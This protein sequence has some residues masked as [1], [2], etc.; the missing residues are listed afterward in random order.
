MLK[1]I[2]DVILTSH[3]TIGE[4]VLFC[5]DLVIDEKV[6]KCIEFLDDKGIIENDD[7]ENKPGNTI[8]LELS[9]PRLNGVGYYQDKSSFLIKNKYEYP[10]ELFYIADLDRFSDELDVI[11]YSRYRS[12][13]DL[14]NSIKLISR[15]SYTDIDID[16]SLIFRD[17]KSLIV[18]L[19]YTINQIQNLSKN[20][21]DGI[22]S[23]VTVY[24]EADSEKKFLFINELIDFLAPVSES[25]RFKVLLENI[26]EF[27]DK[28]NS[29]YQYYLRDFSY[30]KLR[31]EL[32]S[33]VLEFTQK[34]QA[35]I[36]DSQTKLVAIPTAF[37]LVFAAFDFNDLVSVKDGV[38]IA[39]LFIFAIIIQIFLANQYSSLNFTKANI[40]AYKDTFT[41]HLI[42][43]ED[44]FLLID[45][46][47]DKQRKRLC[48]V[49]FLLWSI[50]ISL[51]LI[52]LGMILTYKIK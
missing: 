23:V 29:A 24:N 21:M 51:L 4:G 2:V 37:I 13:V 40:S 11:F 30:N 47:L 35:V 36:N 50:P 38:A 12:V 34:I 17:D 14:I 7:F 6:T 44:K 26:S 9:L 3:R 43:I 1:E 25:L 28:C 20:D 49:A 15:H 16:Y 31:L 22:A 39:S 33:K 42:K 19:I 45:I 18:S 52:W 41:N 48:A 32:D 27:V 46:E 8:N 5:N 10:A